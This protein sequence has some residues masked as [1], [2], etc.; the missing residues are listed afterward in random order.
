MKPA[1]PTPPPSLT[2]LQ[3]WFGEAVSRPLRPGNRMRSEGLRGAS[4]AEEARARLRETAAMGA[5]DRVAVYNRQYWFRLIDVMQTD[6]HKLIGVLGLFRFNRWVVKFLQARPPDSPFL[7]DLD[8]RLP[9]FLREHFQEEHRDCVLEAA[10]YDRAYSD[11]FDAPDA[12]AYPEDADPLTV[13]WR[14]APHARPLWLHWKFREFDPPEDAGE[15]ARE[16]LLPDPEEY[17]VLVY[18]HGRTLYEKRIERGAFLLLSEFREART[19]D[20]AFARLEEKAAPEEWD[21]IEAGVGA[22]FKEFTA[23]GWLAPAPPA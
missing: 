20:E 8:R 12:P 18:R 2:D 4:L 14:L 3:H 1:E 13:R 10:A 5:E 17:G 22:W 21:A 16:T 15:K 6:A 11:A 23:L 19:L 7:A 9:A